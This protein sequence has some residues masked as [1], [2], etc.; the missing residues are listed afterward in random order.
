[1]QQARSVEKSW[2]IWREAQRLIGAGTG[3]LSKRPQYEGDEPGC[4]VRG[5]G[6]RVWDADGNEYIDFR[7]SLGPIT[8]GYCYPAVDDAIRAQLANGII[9]GHPHPLEVELARELVEVLPCAEKV[10]FLKT[11]GE[12]MAACIRLARAYTRRP[13]IVTC[14]YHG[15]LTRGGKPENGVPEAVAA[16]QTGLPYGAIEPFADYLEQHA[17][18]TACVC[19]AAS[20]SHIRPDDGFLPQLRALTREH[21]VLLVY[22]EIVTGF[23]V[24]IGGMQEYTGAVPDL[25]TFAKGIANGMPL[26]CYCGRADILDLVAQAGVSSTYSG[27]T[28]S[29]AAAKAAVHEYRTK[30]V[31]DHLWARGQ[32]LMDGMNMLFEKHGLDCRA[33]GCPACPSIGF[34][35]ADP[36]ARGREQEALWRAAYRH[37]V[38]LYSVSYPN[39]SHTAADIAEALDRLD[40]AMA[41]VAQ[42]R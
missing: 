42:A 27:E 33:I 19:V 15:W 37:G 17:A 41:E 5:K 32:Q 35:A 8:L 3:T 1:M 39:F 10:R 22:D 34:Q 14:G 6:C 11:G 24:R 38:S 40:A 7:N 26:S 25:A 13:G 21:D 28:L 23:R 36:L 20:Y 12:A 30:G 29:L 9:Y 18:A 31:I 2:A 16:L 4:I